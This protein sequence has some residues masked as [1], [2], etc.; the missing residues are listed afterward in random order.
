V[1]RGAL[2]ARLP[3]KN[4]LLAVSLGLCVASFSRTSAAWY[5]PEHV[6]IAKDGIDQLA[7]EIREVLGAGVTRARANGLPICTTVAIGLD[8]LSPQTPIR[9]RAVRA[10]LGIDCV[11]FVALPAIAGD[12]AD[13]VDELRGVVVGTRGRELTTAAAYEWKRFHD[14]MT[15]SPKGAVERM[16]FVH[17]LDVDFYFIDPGYHLRAGRTRA[18]FVDAGR[19]LADVVRS[20][21][22]AGAVD[23]AVGQFAAHHL[24]SLQLAARGRPGDALLEHAFAMHFLQDAFSS[25]HLVMTDRTWQRG[26]DPTRRRHDFFDARGVR[27]TR[28]TSAEPCEALAES[29]ENGLAPCWTTFG[30]GHLGATSDASDRSHVI[31]AAKKAQIELAIAFDSA[32]VERF[33]A[34]LG[35]REKIAFAEYLEPAPW[36]TLRRAARR[37]R[38]STTAHAERVVQGSFAAIAKLRDGSDIPEVVI[39]ERPASPIFGEDIVGPAISPCI[40]SEGSEDDDGCYPGQALAL[41]TV[42]ASLLRPLLVELPTA[43]DDPNALEGE[44]ST[45]HGVAFHLLASAGTGALFPRSAPIDF[46]APALG[47]SMGIAYRFGSYLPGRRDRSAVELNAGVATSLHY[48]SRG[49]AGGHPQVTMLYQE[50]RWPILWELVASYM[51]PIDLRKVH[52]SGSLI[53]LGGV[54]LH[55]VVTDP[56]PRVWGADLEIVSYAIS[57]GRGAYPLYSVSPEVR[58]HMGFADPSVTQPSLPSTLAP[59]VSLTFIGGYATFF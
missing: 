26:N 59:T 13:R 27:V 37:A 36:W 14:E 46:Y 29:L 40:A 42:G 23:N 7:P 47:V 15:R 22:I 53:A 24:R 21:G 56:A 50:V 35:D 45:D 28:A 55:E 30:D 34:S 33:F 43:Q 5:F 9:T 20:A 38:V 6:V 31:R 58:L 16:A 1:R 51:P 54:R 32:R 41:G 17:E 4:A 12:H 19:P 10:P 57:S 49:D 11:P 2:Y 18:H 8:D 25:G 39:G 44:A 52:D 48:D 3:L